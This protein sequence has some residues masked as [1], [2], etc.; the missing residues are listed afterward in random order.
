VGD[1]PVI[2]RKRDAGRIGGVLGGLPLGDADQVLFPLRPDRT[3]CLSSSNGWEILS[4]DE[5]VEL[6]KM[7]FGICGSR[8]KALRAWTTV[9]RGRGVSV[10]VAD[11]PICRVRPRELPALSLSCSLSFA[12]TRLRFGLTS[13]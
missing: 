10:S 13:A 9:T 7:S 3:V 1:V 5:V 4:D 6:L 12:L 2:T 11:S 8:Q